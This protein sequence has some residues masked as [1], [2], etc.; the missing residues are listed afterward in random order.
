M[1]NQFVME[2]SLKIINQV[3]KMVDHY[4]GKVYGE[5]VR[6]CVVTRQKDSLCLV[7]YKNASGLGSF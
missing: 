1:E 7:N 2:E 5:Y 4:Y 3:I 6:D